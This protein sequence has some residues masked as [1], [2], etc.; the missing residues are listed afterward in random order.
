MA[1]AED[2]SHPLVLSSKARQQLESAA[3][4]YRERSGSDEIAENWHSGFV[5]AI[6]TLRRNPDR[7]ATIAE[8]ERFPFVLRELLYGSGRRKT[9]RAIFRMA[10]DTVEVLAIRHLAQRDLTPDDL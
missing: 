10:G 9:H 7:C 5:A 6:D 2:M 8:A 4:W 3:A 1:A